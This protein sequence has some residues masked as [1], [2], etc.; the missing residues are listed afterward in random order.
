MVENKN[1]EV[2]AVSVCAREN[3][4]AMPKAAGKTKKKTFTVRPKRADIERFSYFDTEE[5]RVKAAAAW[6]GLRAFQM[7]MGPG[8]AA[9]EMIANELPEAYR[10]NWAKKI[11][12]APKCWSDSTRH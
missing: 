5:K 6:A 10:R 4:E 1:A 7:A 3:I 12:Q 9:L 2:L 8:H 11:L